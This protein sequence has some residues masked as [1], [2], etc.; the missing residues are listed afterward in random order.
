MKRL[1]NVCALA[2]TCAAGCAGTDDA[3]EADYD[4]VAQAMS[5]LVVT[6][7]NG[8]D[9]GAMV[10]ATNIAAGNGGLTLQV[11]ASGKY[12]AS[13]LGLEYEYSAQCSDAEGQEQQAC[14]ADSD[15]AQ[16]EVNWSGDLELPHLKAAVSR[17]GSW[18]LSDLQSDNVTF[19][20][21]GDFN[22]DLEVSS[23]FR[24]VTRTYTLAYNATY[25]GVVL[26]RSARA[27][28]S[29]RITYSID[30]ERTATG[31][32]RES[33]AH[34]NMDGVLEIHGDGT[35]TLTLDSAYSYQIDLKTAQL[36]KD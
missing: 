6:D 27:L 25:E 33:Q 4:D 7:N 15:S 30:A 26:Q 35:A 31:P 1:M 10:D 36:T 12:T 32:R 5:A 29:G 14:T 23:L 24:S 9:V 19:A 16:I 8:G 28:E 34:F 18:Q 21:A 3:T 17:E 2:A 13:H 20:G 11:S 22:V